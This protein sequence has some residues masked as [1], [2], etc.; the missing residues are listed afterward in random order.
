MER[1]IVFPEGELHYL[2][3]VKAVKNINI[4]I[5]PDMTVRVSSNP[6]TE[7]SEVEKVLTE[8]RACIRSALDRYAEMKKYA[9][10]GHEYVSGECFRLL[11]RDLRLKVV[12]GKKNSVDSDGLYL[13]LTVKENN[14]E[15]KKR[16]IDRWYAQ[17]CEREIGG[18]CRDTYRFFEKYGVEFPQNRFRAMVS[19]WGS[20]QAKRKILTFNRRLIEMPKICIEYVVLHEFVHFLQAD[21]SARFYTRMTAFMPDW[22]ERARLLEKEGVFGIDV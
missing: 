13:F 15:L 4:R 1:T 14:E 16:L 18:I 5:R 2:H 11:G 22:R 9:A 6:Q 19:C 17:A 10:R 8:K 20:C 12:L 7:I 3:E 21:H